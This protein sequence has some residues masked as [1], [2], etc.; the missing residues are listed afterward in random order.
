MTEEI[1]Q[2]VVDKIK[3]L[4]PDYALLA[5][6]DYISMVIDIAYPIAESDG[7]TDDK[8]ITGTALLV[9]D[10]L[11]G[12]EDNSNVASR[13][14]DGVSESYFSNKYVISKWRRLYEMLLSGL[15]ENEYTLHYV[16]IDG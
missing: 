1:K 16:G 2:K 5:P 3:L 12:I 9:L 8:L 15:Y 4:Y 13:Q 6:E 11:V 10:L 14:I 7:L